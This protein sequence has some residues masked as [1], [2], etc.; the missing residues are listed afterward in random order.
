MIAAVGTDKYGGLTGYKRP[1]Q[2][3]PT[4]VPNNLPAFRGVKNTPGDNIR[5][6]PIKSSAAHPD[7]KT[8]VCIPYA[9]VTPLQGRK[10]WGAARR[11]TLCFARARVRTFRAMRTRA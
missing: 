1:L 8:N 5:S 9:R 11:A 3:N 4:R 7:R 6:G 2:G 10:T